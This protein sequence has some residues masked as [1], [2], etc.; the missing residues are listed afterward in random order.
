MTPAQVR[1]REAAI[2]QALSDLATR[3]YESIQM[4]EIAERAGIALATLYRY[5]PSK[6]YLFAVA[7]ARWVDRIRA[8]VGAAPMHGTASVRLRSVL[9]R[10]VD[11]VAQVPNWF[12]VIVALASSRDPLAQRHLQDATA[13]IHRMMTDAMF[14]V[15]DDDAR[16]IAGVM[17]A[18]LQQGWHTIYL[19]GSSVSDL[20]DEI[21][22]TIEM[23]FRVPRSKS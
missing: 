19:E 2:D 7:L 23:L 11:M 13:T 20:H 1:R 10:G 8:E 3:D 9:H 6:E 4:R 16:M 17:A 22:S 12:S 14:D 15:D 18:M 5:F 21:D